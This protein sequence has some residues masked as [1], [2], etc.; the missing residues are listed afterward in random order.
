[1][2]VK[3]ELAGVYRYVTVYQVPGLEQLGWTR[4]KS[5]AKSEDAGKT[6]TTRKSSKRKTK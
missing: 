6:S 3:M 1:M 4:V 5:G 2:F